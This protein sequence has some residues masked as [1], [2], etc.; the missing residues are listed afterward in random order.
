MLE[1][2]TSENFVQFD[3]VNEHLIAVKLEAQQTTWMNQPN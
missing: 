1:I 2:E 3:V